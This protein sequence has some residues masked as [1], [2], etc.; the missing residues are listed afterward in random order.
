MFIVP[1]DRYHNLDRNRVLNLISACNIEIPIDKSDYKYS[2]IDKTTLD[3]LNHIENEITNLFSSPLRF[4]LFKK[5]HLSLLPNYS[6]GN[7]YKIGYSPN[8]IINGIFELLESGN[9]VKFDYS[10]P[11]M[12]G[13]DQIQ[14]KEELQNIIESI[15]VE[16]E[17]LSIT[18]LD[19]KNI[20]KR[21]TY[22]AK[23][24]TLKAQYS[25][26]NDALKNL[27]TIMALYND[28]RVDDM[29]KGDNIIKWRNLGYYL[30]V[31][32]LRTYDKA[33]KRDKDELYLEYPY[34][35]YER[36]SS[37][38]EKDK[39]MLY[40]DS[41]LMEDAKYRNDFIFFNKE[42]VRVF[43]HSPQLIEFLLHYQDNNKFVVFDTL[44]P[45]HM[46]LTE[47][48]LG[49]MFVH[50]L[51]KQGDSKD[52]TE[53]ELIAER[54]LVSKVNFY[55]YNSDFS[56]HIKGRLY[57][58]ID[59]RAGYV[60]FLLDNNYVVLDRFFR[61]TLSGTLAPAYKS[62]VYSMPLDLYV[63]LGKNSLNMRRYIEEHKDDKEKFVRRNY[64]TILES[65]TDTLLEIASRESISRLTADVFI[66]RYGYKFDETFP[67]PKKPKRLSKNNN[68]KD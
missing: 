22:I 37:P 52:K 62:A 47:K 10:N 21:M 64:H 24:K 45:G 25:L 7:N 43:T 17:K 6:G 53:K 48:D 1:K 4:K 56:K 12:M 58:Q 65:Y 54:Q 68:K 67:E 26:A 59:R 9:R 28:N 23:E 31:V 30:S 15:F 42:C 34:K 57:Q 51:S 44:K 20:A 41:L 16:L 63:K 8:E 61:R 40:P 36:C 66:Q 60:V 55:S 19:E 46:M 11:I 38:D 18:L 32:S 39:H 27:D 49:E 33:R 50:S 3:K 5:V 14:I 2:I 13:A 29:L 35:F